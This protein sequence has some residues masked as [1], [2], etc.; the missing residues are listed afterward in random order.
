MN[1][2][3]A[4]KRSRL[5]HGNRKII[6]L[7]DNARPCVALTTQNT[8]IEL[9]WKVMA[10]PVYSSE[11]APSD[12]YLFHLLGLLIYFKNLD[13]KSQ[14]RKIEMRWEIKRSKFI[15]IT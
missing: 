9:G 3:I 12:Y 14:I 1:E 6:L 4:E 13:L 2:K 11:L 7:H 5:D 15:F 10:Y 8:I